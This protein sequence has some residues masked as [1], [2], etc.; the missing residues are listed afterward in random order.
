MLCVSNKS[1]KRYIK[2]EEMNTMNYKKLVSLFAVS[3]LALSACGADEPAETPTDDV[4]NVAE[5]ETPEE[6]EGTAS[7]DL[8]DIAAQNAGDAFPEYGLYVP[9][10]WTADGRVVTY[11]PGEAATIPVNITSDHTEYNVYLVE[12]GV[13]TEVV[14]NEAE[15]EFA[16]ATPS[17]DTTYLVGVSP[18]ALGEAGDEVT[19]EDFYRAETVVFEEVAPAADDAE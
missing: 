8:M 6:T 17:A 10:A 5:T 2:Q 12:N 18:D 14:S 1:K 7:E 16:V 3:T 15:V 13:I 4:E 9:G 19:E 11:A